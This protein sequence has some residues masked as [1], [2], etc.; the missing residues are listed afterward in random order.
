MIKRKFVSFASW[1]CAHTTESEGDCR[2]HGVYERSK[3]FLALLCIPQTLSIMHFPALP[4]ERQGQSA[5]SHT[6]THTMAYSSAWHLTTI[7]AEWFRG[8]DG[9]RLTA[10]SGLVKVAWGRWEF[11]L[12]GILTKHGSVTSKLFDCDQSIRTDIS[13]QKKKLNYIQNT[14]SEDHRGSKK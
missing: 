7:S 5:H 4:V 3:R 2:R 10:A 8:K 9:H 6:C 13:L 12:K 14:C 1:C 11:G